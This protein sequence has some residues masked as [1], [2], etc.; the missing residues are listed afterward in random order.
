MKFMY[1][2]IYIFF[3]LVDDLIVFFIAMFTMKVSGISTKYNKYSHVLGGI[4]MLV[5][6]IL[7]IFKPEWLMFQFK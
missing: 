4:I 2:L 5:V 1:T 6:G 3:F 7:L